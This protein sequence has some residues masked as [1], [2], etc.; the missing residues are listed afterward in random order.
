MYYAEG[1]ETAPTPIGERMYIGLLKTLV[2]DRPVVLN[3][4][5]SHDDKL[6]GLG[7]RNLNDAIIDHVSFGCGTLCFPPT[8]Q[9]RGIR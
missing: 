3:V 8:S 5:I 2:G 9:R 6:H 4:D 1:Y 7:I